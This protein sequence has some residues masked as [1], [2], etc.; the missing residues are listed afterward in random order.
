MCKSYRHFYLLL[1]PLIISCGSGDDTQKLRVINELDIDRKECLEVPKAEF[2]N[3]LCEHFSRFVIKDTRSGELLPVQFFDEDM[4]G[5]LDYL[6]FQPAMSAGETAIFEIFTPEQGIFAP[7]PVNRTF[8]RFVP[9]RTDD[10]A[11]END[12]VAFRTYGPTA[13]KMI[14]DQVIFLF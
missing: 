14:E 9:E 8:S 5:V 12:R 11:W 7:D 6:V 3:I 13:Q 1:L 10:Y 4:D 2:G